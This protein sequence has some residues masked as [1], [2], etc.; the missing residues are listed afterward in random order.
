M[1]PG[2]AGPGLDH[3]ERPEVDRLL[4]PAVLQL[5][6]AVV[7]ELREKPNKCMYGLKFILGFRIKSITLPYP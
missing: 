7:E 3:P 5:Q 4:A 2:L 1:A 6:V